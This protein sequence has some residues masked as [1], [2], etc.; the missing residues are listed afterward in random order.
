MAAPPAVAGTPRLA[1]VLGGL[2]HDQVRT[3]QA[4]QRLPPTVTFAFGPEG[5]DLQAQ[6]N[7]ARAGGHE[8]VLQL[9]E[10]PNDPSQAG[11]AA[12]DRLHRL[13]AR[14]AGYAGILL[15][16]GRRGRMDDGADAER[17][18]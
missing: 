1:L 5:P 16:L 14:F 13:M 15:P 4:G 7:E 6:V 12:I 18:R 3:A 9:P 17:Y 10:A 2:G 11:Q 8:V